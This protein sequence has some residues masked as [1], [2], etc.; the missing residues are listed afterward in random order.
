MAR[1]RDEPQAGVGQLGDQPLGGHDGHDLVGRVGQQQHRHLDERQRALH[2]GELAEQRPLLGEEG[3]PPRLRAGQLFAPDLEAEVLAWV[4]RPA[5]PAAE[6]GEPEAGGP[7]RPPP[8]DLRGHRADDRRGEQPVHDADRAR[9]DAGQQHQGPHPLR[10]QVRR[11]E[12]GA[13]SPGMGDENGGVHASFVQVIKD[14]LGIGREA[15]GFTAAR[16]VSGA[17]FCH[18]V[19]VGRQTGQDGVP[20][21]GAAG[22]AVE[23]DELMRL[24][25]CPGRRLG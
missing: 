8:H 21:G 7:W 14:R 20:V 19:Q 12:R 1:V 3:A 24:R 25:R 16:A 15:T 11:H 10:C 2:L 13:A 22:L 9:A 23:Q 5:F 4:Q 18:R 6:P 17:V